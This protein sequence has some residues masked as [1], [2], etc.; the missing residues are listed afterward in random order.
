MCCSDCDDLPVF[1]RNDPLSDEEEEK[2]FQKAINDGDPEYM[3]ELLMKEYD[4]KTDAAGIFGEQPACTRIEFAKRA[5]K[6]SSATIASHKASASFIACGMA[7]VSDWD[8]AKDIISA[9][10][11]LKGLKKFKPEVENYGSARDEFWEYVEKNGLILVDNKPLNPTDGN[12]L[13]L[14]QATGLSA[15]PDEAETHSQV[16][17]ATWFKLLNN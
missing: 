9:S 3:L 8:Q 17:A 11:M 2:C 5:A 7:M 13:E 1:A 16:G 15:P 6:L 10:E 12:T 4:A 14:L